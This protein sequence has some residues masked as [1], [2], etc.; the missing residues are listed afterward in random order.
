MKKG[1]LIVM[2]LLL[3]LFCNQSFADLY[4][5]S[6]P[7]QKDNTFMWWAYGWPD[8]VRGAEPVVCFQTGYFGMAIH[9]D[10]VEFWNP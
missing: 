3:V 10:K 1:V 5:A 4:K 7:T 8:Q 6:L 2:G 9:I